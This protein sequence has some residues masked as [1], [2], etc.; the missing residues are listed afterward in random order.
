MP[1]ADRPR[2]MLSADDR[3]L[4]YLEDVGRDFTKRPEPAKVQAMSCDGYPK[5]IEARSGAGRRASAPSRPGECGG[6]G[7][8]RPCPPRLGGDRCGLARQPL[9][10]PG[11]AGPLAARR[12]SRCRPGRARMPASAEKAREQARPAPAPRSH[13]DE[14]QDRVGARPGGWTLRMCHVR[15]QRLHLLGSRR[16]QGLNLGAVRHPE[17]SFPVDD[18][19]LHLRLDRLAPPAA[20][21]DL[22]AR[23]VP[24]VELG[25]GEGRSRRKLKSTRVLRL[26]LPVAG[27]PRS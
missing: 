19:L 11:G 1:V 9:R 10:L 16:P 15:P 24:V 7:C 5:A 23:A 6:E 14:L 12:S 21:A 18:R 8:F 13:R 22:S 27:L 26:R 20:R 2:P 25:F 3:V 4:D 17:V